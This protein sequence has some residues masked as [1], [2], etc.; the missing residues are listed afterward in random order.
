MIET[1]S[2]H[3]LTGSI[4]PLHEVLHLKTGT[5]YLEGNNLLAC[6]EFLN[7]DKH[8]QFSG[9]KILEVPEDESYACNSVWVNDTIL[10]PKGFP[11]VHQILKEAGYKIREVDVSEF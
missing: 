1:L 6:G 9:F 5:S 8:P 3:G 4:V 11:K 2:L 10:T 7:A